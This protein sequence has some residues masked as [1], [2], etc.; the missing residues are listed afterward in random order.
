MEARLSPS[1]TLDNRYLILWRAGQGK[2]G[3][4]VYAAKDTQSSSSR[5]VALKYPVKPAEL[6]VLKTLQQKSA[7]SGEECFWM[8]QVLDWGEFRGFSYAATE[9]LSR[10]LPSVFERMKGAS[11]AIRWRVLRVIG[12]MLV[13]RLEAIHRHGFVHC[14]IQPNNIL[15]HSHGTDSFLDELP[16]LVDFGTAMRSP[17]GEPQRPDRGSVDFNSVATASGGVRGP[18]DDLESMGWV[19]SFGLFGELPWFEVTRTARWMQGRLSEE[20]CP[21]VCGE[22]RDAKI[23]VMESGGEGFGAKWE[24]LGDMPLELAKF[25]RLVRAGC[26][27]AARSDALP[28]YDALLSALG[29]QSGLG[30]QGAEAADIAAYRAAAAAA[31]AAVAQEGGEA[32]VEEIRTLRNPGSQEVPAHLVKVEVRHAIMESESMTVTV[33]NTC[34]VLDVRKAVLGRLGVSKLSEVKLV[35]RMGQGDNP[36]FASLDDKEP[37][38]D[39]RKFIAMGRSLAVPLGEQGP[40]AKPGTQGVGKDIKVELTLDRALALQDEFVERFGNEDFQSKLR[41]VQEAHNYQMTPPFRAAHADLCFSVQQDVLPAYGFPPTRM[42]V[43][44]MMRAF[45]PFM[46]NQG[47]QYKTQYINQLIGAPD[48]RQ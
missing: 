34:V 22:V 20:D 43:V 5:K 7:G 2:A 24:C 31:A 39:R 15:M 3:G 1:D 47:I 12:R 32:E 28:D 9:M 38:D 37:I 6:E 16:Y 29:G 40:T 23:A 26:Q 21:V 8:P 48:R 14:D 13:R 35:R 44:V 25:L 46:D 30:T 42:G 19:L 36:T 18:C 41:G 33:M 10:P 27:A 17:G 11:L 4:A 45:R